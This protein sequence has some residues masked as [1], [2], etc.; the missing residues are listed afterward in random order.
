MGQ[1]K[2]LK[3]IL[4]AL[5]LVGTMIGFG[6]GMSTIIQAHHP[7]IASASTISESPMVPATFSELAERV[8]PGVVN[9][10]VVKKVKTV[11]FGFRGNPLGNRIPLETSLPHFPR[12]TLLK[13]SLNSRV[14][15]RDL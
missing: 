1:K 8:R 13:G 2:H 9:I 5:L 14:W 4:I 6:Y 11:D 10:Q 12:E 7:Q 3:R 15:A